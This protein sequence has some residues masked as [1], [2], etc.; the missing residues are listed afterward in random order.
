MVRT[1]N[2]PYSFCYCRYG[3]S[4]TVMQNEYTD[5]WCDLAVLVVFSMSQLVLLRPG[6]T[7]ALVCESAAPIHWFLPA[8]SQECLEL[9]RARLPGRPCIIQEALCFTT[10]DG[11]AAGR[12]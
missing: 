6:G 9:G 12:H 11:P 8:P 5:L 4:G 2:S 10:S 7:P 1:Q 3:L